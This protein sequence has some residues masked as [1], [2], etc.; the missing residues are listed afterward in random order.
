VNVSLASCVNTTFDGVGDGNDIFNI[1][2]NERFGLEA[3]DS[4]SF[5]VQLGA[6]TIALSSP[7]DVY[8]N[9]NSAQF[10]YTPT[11]VDLDSCWLLGN[12]TGIYMIN[13][14]DTGVISGSVNNFNLNLEDGSYLWNIGCN[15]S[16]S[17]SAINGNK[18]FYVDTINPS[19][20]LS[21]PSGEKTSRTVSA[22]WSVSDDSPISCL[23][24]VYQGASLEIGNTSIPCNDSSTSFDVSS[25]ASFVLNFYVNDSAGNTNNTNSSFNVDTGD[26]VIPP[27]N[28]GNSGSTSSGGIYTP[29][30]KSNIGKLVV[31]KLGD[32]IAHEGDMKNISLNVQNIGF[33]FVNNCRLVVS[34]DISSWVYSTQVE[35]IAPGENIDFIFNLNVPEEIGPGD[36]NGDL[37]INCEEGNDIQT[38]SISVPGLEIIKIN[39][40]IQEDNLV[41]I[42]YSFDNS[43]VIGDA[44]SIDIWMEDSDGYEVGRIQDFFDIN[45]QGLIERNVEIEFGGS[46][47]YFVYF[48]L[49]NDLENFVKESIVLGE[50]KATGFAI[51]DNTKNKFIVYI[52][53]V[54]ILAI[55]IFFIWK[56]HGKKDESNPH[57]KKTSQN[58]H[59]WLMRK[60]KK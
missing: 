43:Y 47:I 45:K 10:N 29:P 13:Q 35:G 24:N 5:S 19:L 53:F 55:A 54:L 36:Y 28:P 8:L 48:A 33:Y 18:T 42:R 11:D 2:V 40:I 27:R 51:L 32:I 46:G 23:Y 44:V 16:M 25:D 21:E 57:H 15:D 20:S 58:K 30:N 12:F 34:G 59:N 49:S 6:P 17:N 3:S 9:S 37:E 52:G 1:Y 56:S 31:E 14:T 39:E 26:V 50:T 7:I 4:A 22:S 38:V 60:K 41:K